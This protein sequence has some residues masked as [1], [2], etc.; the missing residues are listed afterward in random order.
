M[1]RVVNNKKTACNR[2]KKIYSVITGMLAGVINGLFGGGGGMIVVPMLVH[3]LGRQT[4]R[5]H[6]TAILIILPLSIVSGLCYSVFGN[7]RIDVVV[8]VGIGV[9]LGGVV[10]A[11]MLSKLS[12]RIVV[13]IFSIVMAIAGLKM[14][15]F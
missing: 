15:L 9:I 12:S 7:V 8:P 5:A 3:L 11:L 2:S 6:A 4:K 10:G 1:K 13:M 14:L